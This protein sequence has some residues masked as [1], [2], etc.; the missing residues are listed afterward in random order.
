MAS[1]ITTKGRVAIS[2]LVAKSDTF[3]DMEAKA[4]A[5]A[6][7]ARPVIDFDSLVGAEEPVAA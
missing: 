6:A 4:A 1:Y 2:E 7:G 5:A 3:I